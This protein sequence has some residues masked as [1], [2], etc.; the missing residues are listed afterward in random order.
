[1]ASLTSNTAQPGATSQSALHKLP[2]EIRNIIYTSYFEGEIYDRGAKSNLFQVLFPA[3]V[4]YAEAEAV[5]LKTRGVLLDRDNA[6]GFEA[7][8]PASRL[9]LVKE[10]RL[11][12]NIQ[13]HNR[14]TAPEDILPPSQK[15]FHAFLDRFLASRLPTS[16]PANP[17]SLNTLSSTRVTSPPKLSLLPNIQ[18]LTLQF[19]VHDLTS[20]GGSLGA[21]RRFDRVLLLLEK[22]LATFQQL[23][24]LRLVLLMAG[25]SGFA[26]NFFDKV[27][28]LLGVK[29]ELVR[30]MRRNGS[31][32]VSEG[33]GGE[34]RYSRTDEWVWRALEEGEDGEKRLRKVGDVRGREERVGACSR[35]SSSSTCPPAPRR[36]AT[37]LAFATSNLSIGFIEEVKGDSIPENSFPPGDST[38][39]IKLPK[40]IKGSW[41]S[42]MNALQH[43][44]H[45][46]LTTAIIFEDDVNWDIHLTSQLK[47]F[48]LTSRLLSNQ[49]FS[50]DLPRHNIQTS[51][52]PETEESIHNDTS[53]NP[54]S[55]N[56][57]SLPLSAFPSPHPASTSSP[58]G[59][60]TKWDVLCPNILYP[61]PQPRLNPPRKPQRPHRTLPQAPLDALA[62][63]HNPHTK[64]YRRAT[65]G[66]LCTVAYAVNQHG[67]RRLLAELGVKRWGRIWDVE[68]GGWRAGSDLPPSSSQVSNEEEGKVDGK[69]GNGGKEPER[70]CLTVQPPIFAHHHPAGEESNISKLGSK[71]AREVETKYVRWS[72]RMNLDRLVWGDK[73]EEDLVDQWPE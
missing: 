46:N 30:G 45:Q 63:S 29:G 23:K 13:T 24:E 43:I 5:Y 8:F 7:N 14:S 42:H 66:A 62:N 58:Y 48:A 18:T 64:A 2:A 10:L 35:S 60:P 56:L 57:Y 28:V 33:G 61:K 52:N 15:A 41:R 67:A 25:A 69:R 54:I 4:L 31:G 39:S 26:A 11:D 3:K 22:L 44:V 50:T 12:I 32:T 70:V 20:T 53:P 16:T 71:Y 51:S 59:D 65:G 27:H 19:Q 55:A 6:L 36:D 38:E 72:L 34:S 49:N 37:T 21:L 1:M 68:F 40:G 17:A 9:A 47:A 73:K